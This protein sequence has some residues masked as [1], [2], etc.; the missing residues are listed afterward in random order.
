MLKKISAIIMAMV[1]TLTMGLTVY[2]ETGGTGNTGGTN[3]PSN[4]TGNTV[5]TGNGVPNNYRTTATDNRNWGWIGLLGLAG[6]A[7]LRNRDRNPQK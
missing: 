1:L 7:G 5:G 4:V 6:L 3:T 2:A